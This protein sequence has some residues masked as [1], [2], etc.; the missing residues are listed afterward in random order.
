MADTAVDR[1]QFREGMTVL[2]AE[3]ERVGRVR[4]VHQDAVLVERTGH[5]AI[6][7]PLAF[8]RYTAGN[9]LVLTIPAHKVSEMHWETSAR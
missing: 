2:S 5:P 3:G 6:H 8:I 1:S 9:D 7:V 4:E